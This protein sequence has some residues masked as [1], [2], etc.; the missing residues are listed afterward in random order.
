MKLSPS[1]KKA[2]TRIKKFLGSSSDK[3]IL[4]GAAGT[5]KTTLVMNVLEYAQKL[6]GGSG[7]WCPEA[8]TSL[9]PICV[10]SPTHKAITHAKNTAIAYFDKDIV[11][12]VDFRTIHSVLGMFLNVDRASG[13]GWLNTTDSFLVDA[14]LHNYKIIICDEYSMING[15]VLNELLKRQREFNFKILFVGDINQLPPVGLEI[16]PVVY[17]NIFESVLTDIVRY[18]GDL[19]KIATA[20]CNDDTIDVNNPFVF[21]T[22]DD[23]MAINYTSRKKWF[24]A[25]AEILKD[26]D[27]RKDPNKVRFLA[28]RNSVCMKLNRDI[29]ETIHGYEKANENQF[30]PGDALIALKNCEDTES[31]SKETILNSCE[32][33]TVIEPGI[34]ARSDDD[35]WDF[36]IVDAKTISESGLERRVRLRIL[37]WNDIDRYEKTL[38]DMETKR[39]I[40]QLQSSA[41]SREYKELSKEM[42]DLRYQFNDVTYAYAITVHKSQGSTFENVFIDVEDIKDKRNRTYKK[43]LYTA[44]TRASKTLHTSCVNE[45]QR[46]SIEDFKWEE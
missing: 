10:C 13:K 34:K 7:I 43:M 45:D 33:L 40:I 1:Q 23:G 2:L 37:D 25:G 46:V 30:L 18:D 6:Y 16:T 5:G 41:N 9:N 22:S 39:D 20:I 44:V 17:H 31:D 19:I 28:W 15:T 12:N 3:H 21:Y 36:W 14:M 35:L 24:E 42:E 4:T 11:F 8:N 32:E 29:R 27:F 26:L 38:K